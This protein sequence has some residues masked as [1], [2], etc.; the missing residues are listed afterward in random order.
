MN[1]AKVMKRLNLYL[2]NSKLFEIGWAVIKK[3][4]PEHDQKLTFVRFAADQ[5][6][7]AT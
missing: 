4:R 2:Q 3:S 7:I 1:Y 6:Y 5:K